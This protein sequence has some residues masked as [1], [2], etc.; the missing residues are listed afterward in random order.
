MGSRTDAG[1]LP[2]EF[3]QLIQHREPQ[4]RWI[5][6]EW[7]SLQGCAQRVDVASPSGAEEGAIMEYFTVCHGV[8]SGDDADNAFPALAEKFGCSPA[9]NAESRQLPHAENILKK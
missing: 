5:Q 9:E 1:P 6:Q 4:H 7:G 3:L 8:E 2:D